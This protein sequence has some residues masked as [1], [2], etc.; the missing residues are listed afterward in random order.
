MQ[1]AEQKYYQIIPVELTSFTAKAGVGS[2]ILNWTTATEI[3]NYGFEIER[4]SDGTWRTVGFKEGAGTSTEQRSYT[5]T[6]DVYDV[7]SGNLSY[8]L[9]Q[10]DYNGNVSYSEVIEVKLF[11]VVY[12]LSQNYP[13]PFNPSTVI[14]FSIPERESVSLDVYN[15]LGQKV[16]SIVNGEMEAGRYEFRFD[17]AN[18]SAGIYFYTINA[19]SF[20]STKKMMLI[21]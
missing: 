16:S 19:G 21:K 3:N 9:K 14:S 20:V 8:R 10:I 1:E 2:V 15:L 5:F 7:N 13:N 18:L 6:D 12:N 17:A 11:P 4:L